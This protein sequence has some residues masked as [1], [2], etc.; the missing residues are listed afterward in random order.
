MQQLQK[1]EEKEKYPMV[2]IKDVSSVVHN[3]ILINKESISQVD[4]NMKQFG[5]SEQMQV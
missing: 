3:G 1:E 5:D 2:V 4:L